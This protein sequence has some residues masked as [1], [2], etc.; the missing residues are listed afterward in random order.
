MAFLEI[1][2]LRKRF[3]SIEILKEID[4]ALDKGGLSFWSA[5]PAAEN[6]RF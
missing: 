6:R 3:G 1:T 2:G 5:R 4:L